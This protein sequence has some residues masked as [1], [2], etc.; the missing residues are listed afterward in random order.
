MPKRKVRY[1]GSLAVTELHNDK[2]HTHVIVLDPCESE[3]EDMVSAR[4]VLSL[5]TH[6]YGPAKE[7]V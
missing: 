2:S 5:E 6:A 7:M 1:D 3:L 4:T